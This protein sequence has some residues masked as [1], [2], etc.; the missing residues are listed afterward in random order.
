MRFVRNASR[1][2]SNPATVSTGGGR[3]GPYF[4]RPD[5]DGA[6]RRCPR[7]ESIIG[8]EMTSPAAFLVRRLT[9]AHVGLY[10]WTGGRIGGRGVNGVPL[11][12]LTV[13]G[14]RSG[15]PRT[16]PIAYFDHHLGYV[17]VGTGLGGS[18]KV[19][20]W[21]RNLQIAGRGRVEVGNSIQDVE[22][23]LV[24]R[25]DRERLWADVLQSAPRFARFQLRSKRTF[26]L[27][28]L[29]PR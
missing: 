9:R 10:R 28:I 3:N 24:P 20:R 21:F 15:A 17:V 6:T 22:A 7:R 25:D 16:V 13:A 14:R 4:H 18:A 11:L 23:Q 26:P 5:R 8:V 1:L 29:T 12:L 27:A 2:G 19:P